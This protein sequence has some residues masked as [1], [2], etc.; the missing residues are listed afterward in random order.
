MLVL[1]PPNAD[2]LMK[3]DEFTSTLLSLPSDVDIISEA[4]Y[5][6][7]QTMDGRRFADEFVRRRKLADRGIVPPPSDAGNSSKAGGG[8]SEVAKKGGSSSDGPSTQST[9]GAFR[10]VA[11]KKKGARK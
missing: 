2:I 1:Q 4:I 8:W 11:G 5:A 6:S 10:V 3:V 9:N 7:S